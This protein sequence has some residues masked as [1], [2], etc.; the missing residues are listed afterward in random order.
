VDMS[1]LVIFREA[2]K[3]DFESKNGFKLTYTHFIMYAII[4]ALKDHPMV[5]ASIDGDNIIK[6]H[7]INLGC[8]VAVPG[9]GLVVPVVKN[10]GDL[11]ITGLA[12]HVNE[13]AGKAR[14]KKLG[15]DEMQGGTFTF[16]NVGSFG[17]IFATPVILQPQVGIMAAGVIQ[18][19]PVVI[20]D[21]IVIR[22]MMYL[23]HTYDHRLVDGEL[24]GLFLASVQRHLQEMDPAQIL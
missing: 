5:N 2:N 10:A 23:T 3:K 17:T 21:D 12:R 4:Q 16:T 7:D 20:N 11:N 18:K 19:K 15:L 6:K 9:S 1:D 24:G 13:L 14:N 8:A 22:S